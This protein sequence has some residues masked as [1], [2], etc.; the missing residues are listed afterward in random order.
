MFGGLGKFILL[1]IVVAA[2]WYGIKLFQRRTAA[3]ER[4]GSQDPKQT[5]SAAADSVENMRQC[6]ACQAYSASAQPPA[7]DRADCPYAT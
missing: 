1:G 2:V 3:L 6:S 7:C 5:E 4:R